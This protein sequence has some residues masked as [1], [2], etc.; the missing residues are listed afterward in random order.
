MGY[1]VMSAAK[2]GDSQPRDKMLSRL[3]AEPRV[4]VAADANCP[5][6]EMLAAYADRN[7][8][9]EEVAQLEIH[10]ADCARC[11]EILVALVVS[12]EELPVGETARIRKTVPSTVSALRT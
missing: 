12:A 8:A 11:Q 2:P 5:D 10:L 7:L 1:K 4:P 9:P 3:L 6:A